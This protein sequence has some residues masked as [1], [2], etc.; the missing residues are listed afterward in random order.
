[1]VLNENALPPNDYRLLAISNAWLDISARCFHLL[2]F[3]LWVGSSAATLLFGPVV[4]ARFL[5][6]LLVALLL[7]ILSGVATM[8]RWTPFD[9]PSYF[10]NF[11]HLSH[12]RFGRTYARFMAAKHVLVLAAIILMAIWTVRYRSGLRRKNGTADVAVRFLAGA[13]LCIGLVIGYIMMIIL[14]LHEGVDHAL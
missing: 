6:I 9:V 7:Q 5:S 11:E 12:I 10:W 8:D 3:G 13:T 4:A 14:L 2:G 1:V